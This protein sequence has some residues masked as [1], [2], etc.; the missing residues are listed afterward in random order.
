MYKG[1]RNSTQPSVF[2]SPFG[3]PGFE[4][5]S[6]PLHTLCSDL[7]ALTSYL[8]FDFML[9]QLNIF[10]REK[11][12]QSYRLY[13][14]KRQFPVSP[15]AK[16]GTE[17]KEHKFWKTSFHSDFQKNIDKHNTQKNNH[18]VK[19]GWFPTFLVLTSPA[20]SMRCLS[21]PE[22]LQTHLQQRSCVP[23]IRQFS[24]DH[25]LKVLIP[26][27]VSTQTH[28]N[29]W[30]ERCTDFTYMNDGFLWILKINVGKLYTI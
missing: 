1:K 3:F 4:S 30:D 7:F 26:Q 20:V 22:D 5:Y 23:A 2:H 15:N 16:V 6:I 28:K 19:T 24:T 29:L 12:R 8:H 25:G 9:Q 11:H 10:T 18:L 27:D 14:F 21:P 13:G 17:R